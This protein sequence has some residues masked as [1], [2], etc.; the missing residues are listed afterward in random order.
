MSNYGY[1]SIKCVVSQI[2]PSCLNGQET[3]RSWYWQWRWSW[4]WYIDCWFCYAWDQTKAIQCMH[5]LHRQWDSTLCEM[6]PL[7]KRSC[8]LKEFF[9]LWHFVSHQSF[10]IHPQKTCRPFPWVSSLQ[11]N[12]KLKRRG[13]CWSFRPYFDALSRQSCF[14]GTPKTKSNTIEYW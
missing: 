11:K 13:R 3:S 7:Q 1:M 14:I 6:Q 9:K 8:L 10:E 2:F 4:R 12:Q 5:I